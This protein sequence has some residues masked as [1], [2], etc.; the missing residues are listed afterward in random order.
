MERRALDGVV[1]RVE[2]LVSLYQELE[3]EGEELE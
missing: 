1:Q 2:D 3:A